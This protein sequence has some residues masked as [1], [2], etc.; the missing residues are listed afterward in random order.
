MNEGKLNKQIQRAN[1]AKRLLDDPLLKEGFE[2]LFEQY[3]TEI[4]KTN[5]KDHEQRQVLWM[6][7]NLLD[8]IKGH[9]VSVMETGKLASTELE[10]LTRQSK[11]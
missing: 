6:A 9:L 11:K 1:Q 8:K 2:Y 4:F 5:Y 7:F 3:R 10:N